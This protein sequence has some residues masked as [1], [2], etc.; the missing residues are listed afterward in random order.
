VSLCARS[1]LGET[2]NQQ[3]NDKNRSMLAGIAANE[4]IL[5]AYLF[6]TLVIIWQPIGKML[7]FWLGTSA[8]GFWLLSFYSLFQSSNP[9]N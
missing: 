1:E 6:Y 9:K 8:I 4:F 7:V 5:G 2:Q 3:K